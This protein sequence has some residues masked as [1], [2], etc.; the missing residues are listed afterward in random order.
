LEQKSPNVELADGLWADQPTVVLGG[1]PSLCKVGDIAQLD[2]LNCRV[3]AINRAIELPVKADIWCW[4]DAHFYEWAVSGELGML[5]ELVAGSYTGLRLTRTSNHSPAPKTCA[6][7]S[8]GAYRALPEQIGRLS[9]SPGHA[10]GPSIAGGA[11]VGRTTGFWALNLAYCLGGD[12]IFLFGYDCHGKDGEEDWWHDGYP[13]K[14]RDERTYKGMRDE[15]EQAAGRCLEEGRDV[16]NV[17]P[18]T[19]IKGFHV[20][21]SIGEMA[22]VLSGGS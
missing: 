19:T 10:L 7:A 1:G 3:I 22:E 15:F 12:P 11:C 18:G 14:R 13:R 20:L 16:Y 8:C 21:D 4:L 17:S 9:W 5:M 6:C 2:N